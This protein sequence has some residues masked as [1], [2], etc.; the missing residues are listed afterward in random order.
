MSSQSPRQENSVSYF[1]EGNDSSHP[2]RHPHHHHHHDMNQTISSPVIQTAPSDHHHH[3]NPPS[4]TYLDSS[5]QLRKVNAVIK[6]KA[7]Y[8]RIVGKGSVFSINN[9]QKPAHRQSVG[10]TLANWFSRESPEVSELCER[11]LHFPYLQFCR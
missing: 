2:P 6:P 5:Q 9:L 7:L 3:H 8:E 1:K 10:S 4:S 11:Y